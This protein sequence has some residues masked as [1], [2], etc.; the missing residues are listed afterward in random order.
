VLRRLLKCYGSFPMSGL[1]YGLV[2]PVEPYLEDWSLH[3]T[4]LEVAPGVSGREVHMLLPKQK[5][6]TSFKSLSRF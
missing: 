4:S 3:T 5:M 2:Y 6:G 1:I